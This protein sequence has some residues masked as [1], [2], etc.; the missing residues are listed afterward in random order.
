MLFYVNYT[1]VKEKRNAER[2]K[3]ATVIATVAYCVYWLD[4]SSKFFPQKTAC[5]R[6]AQPG[7]WLLKEVARLVHPPGQSQV[8]CDYPQEQ[9]SPWVEGLQAQGMQ[10]PHPS[11]NTTLGKLL[12]N[13]GK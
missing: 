9:I 3:L 10:I 13:T 7:Y 1:S 6:G 11:S 5:N 8:P 2:C 4:A 12:L